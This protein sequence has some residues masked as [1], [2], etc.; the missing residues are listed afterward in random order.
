MATLETPLVG[1][2]IHRPDAPAHMMR[3]R[4][5]EREVTVRLGEETIAVSRRAM[6]LVE[7]GRDVYD[8]VYYP[9][10]DDVS[11]DLVPVDRSTHCPLKGNTTYSDLG[12]NGTRGAVEEIG[13]S[14]TEPLEWAGELRGLIA[15]DPKRVRIEIAPISR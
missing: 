15:F 12:A 5:A 1:D 13:W 7:I 6:L 10:I 9:P 3:I 8:P 4:P 2:M 11:A 14:Y